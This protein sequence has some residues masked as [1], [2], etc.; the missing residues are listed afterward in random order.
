MIFFTDITTNASNYCLLNI[1][2]YHDP[3]R[4][5]K[6]LIFIDPGV[7]ELK[8]TNEYSH[9]KELHEIVENGLDINEFIS[10]D[11]P[12]DMNPKYTKEFIEKSYQNNV[13]YASNL[14]YICTIQ[15]HFGSYRSFEYEA[16][17]LRP[18]WSQPGKIIG[19]GNMCRIMKTNSFTD[20]VYRYIC[21]NMHGHWVHVY[22]MPM[23]QIKKYAKQ[24][25]YN[26][27][28]L[29]VDSTKWTKRIHKRPPLDKKICCTKI[30]RDLFFTE[31]IKYIRNS[32]IQC[33]H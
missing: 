32:G 8:K 29:S 5:N 10:I 17:R 4:C 13:K 20:A 22:G 26:G 28:E 19:I 21:N 31:Y 16:E 12:C 33:I 27:I 30:T 6:Y 24:L 3:R 9:I 1:K 14:H 2:K 25:E 23:K 7:Y 18:I 11:Y 15:M